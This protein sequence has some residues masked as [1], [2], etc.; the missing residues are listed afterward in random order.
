MT[1]FT[2]SGALLAVV[3]R[4][5]ARRRILSNGVS[6]K[7]P[8]IKPDLSCRAK[9]R[10]LLLFV[11]QKSRELSTGSGRKTGRSPTC[12]LYGPE[13]WPV[14]RNDRQ[15]FAAL[16]ELPC[17]FAG[18]PDVQTHIMSL[19]ASFMNLAGTDLI[20]ILL[21]ILVLFGAKKLP[22]LAK[23][24]GQAVREFQKAKDEFS[25]ELNKA[26]KTDEKTVRPA[27]ANVPRIEP[28]TPGAT[29]QPDPN[30]TVAP[31]NRADQ[32]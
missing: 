2:G 13:S 30:Q 17:N 3:G 8:T 20:V 5:C 23:G 22:E 4:Q 28:G 32:V 21:I 14:F 29:A 12:R 25:D 24:M 16:V 18:R 19:L 9:P 26:G 11:R 1:Q 10:H 7:R 6:Q 31:G 27:Q 15:R